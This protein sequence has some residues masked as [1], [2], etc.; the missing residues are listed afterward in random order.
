VAEDIE[1]Y[2]FFELDKKGNPVGITMLPSPETAA[3]YAD[4]KK[5]GPEAAIRA[6]KEKRKRDKDAYRFEEG[7]LNRMGYQL[8]GMKEI[9]VAIEVFKLNV[10]LYPKSANVYDSLGEAYMVNGDV[11]LAIAN[12][13]KSLK[14]DPR[15]TNAVEKLKELRRREPQ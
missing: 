2:V 4:I 1:A 9:K 10:E 12:Y 6:Y 13:K 7:E 15:N 5:K 14:L 3:L 11:E 8:L